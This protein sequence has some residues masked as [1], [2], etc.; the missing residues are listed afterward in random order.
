MSTITKLLS[1][2]KKLKSLASISIYVALMVIAA[3]VFSKYIDRES[4]QALVQNSGGL[5]IVVYFLIEVVY[6]TL[7]PLFN[8]AILIASGYIFGGHVGFAINFFATTLGLF[9]I[10][11]LVKRY[12]RPLLQRVISENFYDRFDQLTQK[13]GP[14]TLLVV[15]VL[16]LTPDDELT[17]IVAAGPIGFKRFILPIF[18]GTLAKSAYSYIGDMGTRGI[19]IATYARLIL[20]VVGLIAVGLQ[21]RFLLKK[22]TG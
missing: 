1:D 17:Y 11:F 9:L 2:R 10:V 21:E 6:V 19:V 4:L 22:R 16:P 8:T 15:Y 18:L 12:G 14:I 13:I 3:V 5:G 7:T 20:L